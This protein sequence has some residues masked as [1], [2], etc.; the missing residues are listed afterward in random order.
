MVARKQGNTLLS[1]Q[2]TKFLEPWVV[3]RNQSSDSLLSEMGNFPHGLSM[4]STGIDFSP[5]YTSE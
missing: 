5:S 1:F 3:L 2:Y 4:N